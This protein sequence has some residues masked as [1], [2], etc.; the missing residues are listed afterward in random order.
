MEEDKEEERGKREEE[1]EGAGLS[2]LTVLSSP[3]QGIPSDQNLRQSGREAYKHHVQLTL[4]SSP[5]LNL[6][7][8]SHLPLG[9]IFPPQ[10]N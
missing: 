2:W 5:G 8:L 1:E 4:S 9:C 10:L 7:D 3:W 6:R